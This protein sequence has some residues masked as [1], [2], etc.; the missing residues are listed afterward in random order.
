[1]TLPFALGLMAEALL[2]LLAAKLVRDAVCAL[3]G[4]Q[5]NEQIVAGRSAAAVTQGGY[6]LG[7]LLGFLGSVSGLARGE[8]FFAVA[9]GVAVAGLVAIALQLLA[10]LI[11]DKLIFRGVDD[12]T[13]AD[14][15][16]LA[17]AVGKAAVSVAT[18]LVLRGAMEAPDATLLG[19]VAWFAAGQVV[20]VLAVVV[21][22]R[23]TPYDDLAEIR[24]TNLAA[25][26]PIAGILMAVGFIMET[27]LS[28]RAGDTF[29]QTALRTTE[30]LGLGLLLVYVFRILGDLV[31]L[32]RMKLAQAIVDHKNVGAGL[33]E[34]ISYVLASLLVTFFLT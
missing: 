1:M 5:V 17:L 12:G 24:R 8:G 22:C 14:A 32:P 19:R 16:N 33:Q 9:A 4:T 6:L 25:G 28:G 34:G 2:I 27:A 18:G 20:M 11:S 21:Y 7:V 29:A 26:F 13:N 23:L 15:N 3:R 10:D 30:F 31:L